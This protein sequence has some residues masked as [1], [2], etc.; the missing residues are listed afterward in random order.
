M[1]ISYITHQ[2]RK[3]LHVDFAGIK[4][5]QKVIENLEEMVKFYKSSFDE[6]YLLLDISGTFTDPEIMNK[7]KTYG[8]EYFRGKSKKRA[9]LGV[10]GIKK[11]L[12][13]A[14]S[15]FTG[16]EVATFDSLEEA[17]NYLAA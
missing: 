13:N 9:I 6:I 3:I 16:T 8:K 11:L 17:K 7:L 14:Y 12:L 4:D 15:L 10:T 1:P 5:K 2:G